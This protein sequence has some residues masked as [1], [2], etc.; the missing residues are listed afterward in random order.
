MDPSFLAMDLDRFGRPDLARVFLRAYARASGDEGIDELCRYFRMHYAIVR[1]MTES[2]R[3]HQAETP[4][5]EHEGIASMVRTYAQL[6]AGYVVEPATLLVMGLPA[7]GKSTLAS[8]LALGLRASVFSSD[9]VRKSMLGIP[10]TERAGPA[11]YAPD[12]TDATYRELSRHVESAT[13]N[14][15]VDA[16]QRACAHRAPLVAA[17]AHRSDAWLLV[18][19]EADRATIEA[20]MGRRARDRSGVSDADLAVH[21]RLRNEFQPPDEIPGAHRVRLVSSDRG[22]WLDEAALAV[23]G[24]LLEAP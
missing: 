5:S 2:I 17:A 23:L 7:S 10:P 12:A 15:I 16:S 21:D 1:A 6:A 20:R 11:A 19:V 8:H 18:E 13:G 3:L 14:A 22:G 4:A 24:R 9:L